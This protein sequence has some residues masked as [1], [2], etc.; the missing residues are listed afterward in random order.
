MSGFSNSPQRARI[1]GP[2]LFIG[3]LCLLGALLIPAGAARGDEYT[4]VTTHSIQ[5]VRGT[6]VIDT[7][8]GDI[9]IQGWDKARVEVQAE[10]LV[11]AGSEKKSRHLFGR[12]RC[13]FRPT[14]RN[15]PCT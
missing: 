8:V 12:L 9:Y 7:R 15:A 1:F 3:C 4:Q 6:V 5:L 11:R 14:K 2:H 10:K 13:S